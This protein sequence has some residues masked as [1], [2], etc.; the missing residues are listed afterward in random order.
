MGG[1]LRSR[2]SADT[3]KLYEMSPLILKG[4]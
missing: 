4:D 3:N 1:R 2:P